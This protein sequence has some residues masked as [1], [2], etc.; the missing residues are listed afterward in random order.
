M[1]S[2][3]QYNPTGRFSGLAEIYARARPSYPPE[4]IAY[5]V[6]TCGLGPGSLLVDV[7]CGTGISSR[8]M[9]QPGIRVVG[10]EPNADMRAQAE[11]EPWPD[12]LPR[13]RYQ[14]G[15]AEA[16]G[17]PEGAADAVLSAQAFHWFKP[18]A[19]LQEFHRILRPGGWVVLMW[20]ERDEQDPFTADYGAVIRTGPQAELVEH[21]RNHG[22]A[23]LLESSLFRDG[24]RR[25]LPNE[26]VLDEASLLERALS[27]SYAPREA[28]AVAQFTAALT[29]VFRRYE[30]QGRVALRYA[31]EVFCARKPN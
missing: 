26:Q 17:L 24:R 2:L 1:P 23:L 10:I 29:S 6:E 16:T 20:N 21:N 13:P 7:G 22:G 19:A 9:A 28:D 25:D 15:Q 11:A 18:D 3:D 14:P 30:S 4:A 12:E 5:I 8:L 27:A 31:T